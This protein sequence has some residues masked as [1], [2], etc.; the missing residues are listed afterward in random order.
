MFQIKV[1]KQRNRKKI[2]GKNPFV[3]LTSFKSYAIL[4]VLVTTVTIL[5]LLSS[6]IEEI[7]AQKE[8]EDSLNDKDIKFEDYINSKDGY[9]IV[10]PSDAERT[11]KDFEDLVP[12]FRDKNGEWEFVITAIRHTSIDNAESAIDDT[13]KRIREYQGAKI[14]EEK[15]PLTVAGQPAFMFSYINELYGKEKVTYI[16]IYVNNIIYSFEVSASIDKFDQYTDTF[17]TISSHLN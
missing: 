15:K 14:V 4:L 7:Y 9:K 1:S 17:F 2:N 10:Y 13:I 5:I 12:T 3:G 8:K 11:G 6:T 16:K